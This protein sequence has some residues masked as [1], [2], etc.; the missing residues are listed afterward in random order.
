MGWSPKYYLKLNNLLLKI[1]NTP[2]TLITIFN[3]SLARI[4]II[5]MDTD[6]SEKRD[7]VGEFRKVLQSQSLAWRVIKLVFVSFS[8]D[9]ICWNGNTTIAP[10]IG[11]NLAFEKSFITAETGIG[12]VILTLPIFFRAFSCSILWHAN[13][14]SAAVV[15]L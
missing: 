4:L 5:M 9:L 3:N 1:G 7:W 15:F 2:K 11:L 13:L 10:T 12:Y 14:K 8:N 6:Q